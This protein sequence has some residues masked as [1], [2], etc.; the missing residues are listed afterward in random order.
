MLR[1][2]MH[3]A[4]PSVS[5]LAGSGLRPLGWALLL[6]A[7]GTLGCEQ[8]PGVH[9]VYIQVGEPE[10]PAEP[11]AL[12]VIPE[13]GPAEDAD[14]EPA[15]LEEALLVVRR[16]AQAALMGQ[17]ERARAELSALPPGT[18]GFPQA[19]LVHACIALEAGNHPEA[20]RELASLREALPTHPAPRVLERLLEVR[21]Q[22]PALGWREAFLRAWN[23]AGRP[24]L[25]EDP[26]LSELMDFGGGRGLEQAWRRTR[27][28]DTRLMLVFAT[29]PP[30]EERGRFVLE[31]LPSIQEPEWAVAAFDYVRRDTLPEELRAQAARALVPKLDALSAASPDTQQL[32]VLRVLGLTELTAPLTSEE[33]SALEAIAP[34]PRWRKSDLAGLHAHARRHLE[35]AGVPLAAGHA[36]MAV[37]GGLAGHAPYALLKR[38]QVSLEHLAPAERERLGHVLWSIG[39]RLAAEATVLEQL[40]GFNLMRHGA[41]ALKDE[42]RLQQVEAWTREVRASLQASH[43]AAVDR[44]PLHSL[45]ESLLQ[46]TLRDEG[47]HLRGFLPPSPGGQRTD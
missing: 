25:R 47:A 8:W 1:R 2:A 40:V 28:L 46:A 34:L 30:T 33:L 23:E 36:F 12:E 7:I 22:Q 4:P 19:L 9:D 35:E 5:L 45:Q 16:A 38:A 14:N 18:P 27:A 29:F 17:L 37:T 44:W 24:D 20:A 41:M 42:A 31:Q 21:R 43:Q 6:L 15:R 32:R 3:H 13:Q 11:A 10:R 39:S 26:L